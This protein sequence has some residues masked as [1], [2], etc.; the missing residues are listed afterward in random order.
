MAAI[1]KQKDNANLQLAAFT[2]LAHLG[3]QAANQKLLTMPA[4][5]FFQ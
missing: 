1:G 2:A 3:S 5:V 4:F